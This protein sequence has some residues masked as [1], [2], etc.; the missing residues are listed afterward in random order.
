MI[1]MLI[2]GL[3]VGTIAKAIM[4]G[5]APGGILMTMLLGIAGS[6]LANWIGS[7]SGYY[8]F[9]EVPGLI[10]SVLGA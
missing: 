2:V 9:G 7:Q 3:I 8:V 4:P 1:W 10:S 5:P 6:I